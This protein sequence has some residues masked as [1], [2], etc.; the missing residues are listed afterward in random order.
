MNSL[1]VKKMNGLP[2]SMQC[3][4][5]FALKMI[6]V[7]FMVGD[8]IHQMFYMLGAP[9]WLV[10]GGRIVMPIFLFMLSEGYHFTRDK[11]KYMLRLLVAFWLMGAGNQLLGMLLPLEGVVLMNSMFGTMFLA[12]L[13]MWLL[14]TLFAAAKQKDMKKILFSIG[15]LLLPVAA[16]FPLFFIQVMPVTLMRLYLIM[17]P[18]IVTVEAGA[19]GILLAV[20]FRYL[21][22]YRWLQVLLLALMA[23]PSFLNADIQWMMVFAAVPI[24]LYNRTPGRKSKYFF[25]VFYPA[26][27]YLL[28]MVS[29]C[30]Q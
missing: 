11:K 21:R 8:H 20:G 29:Y 23:L 7:V 9:M 10:M 28:Y 19:F 16:S 15:G 27:I 3:L 2:V 12:V 6:A 18:S 14:D 4:S 17:V 5:G 24:L 13:Y 25:Y 26:H 30:I 22:E 1:Q